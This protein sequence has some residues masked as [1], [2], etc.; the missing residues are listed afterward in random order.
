MAVVVAVCVWGACTRARA[1]CARKG[2]VRLERACAQKRPPERCPLP[3]GAGSRVSITGPARALSGRAPTIRAGGPPAARCAR[4]PPAPPGRAPRCAQMLQSIFFIDGA[5]GCV[6]THRLQSAGAAARGVAAP[7]AWAQQE[8]WLEGHPAGA[9]QRVVP[10]F[11]PPHRPARPCSA[12][13]RARSLRAPPSPSTVCAAT[14]CWRSTT[15]VSRPAG[16]PR[17]GPARGARARVGCWQHARP[18]QPPTARPPPPRAHRHSHHT[19]AAP[20]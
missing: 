3:G 16:E 18:R 2:S 13:A 11:G 15:R 8:Q 10:S 4:A 1:A 9:A 14:W 20:H 19:R 17:A 12:P 5:S 7:R 6:A